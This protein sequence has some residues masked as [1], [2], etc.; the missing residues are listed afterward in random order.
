MDSNSSSALSPKLLANVIC[1]AILSEFAHFTLVVKGLPVDFEK[2]SEYSLAVWRFELEHKYSN[3]QAQTVLNYV[4]A[5]LLRTV[6]NNSNESS[7]R[8]DLSKVYIQFQ[9]F[10]RTPS[11]EIMN[12]FV[13][14]FRRDVLFRASSDYDIDEFTKCFSTIVS[15]FKYYRQDLDSYDVEF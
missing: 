9:S 12:E 2:Y 3:Q 14:C 7:Y 13:S 8:A 1:S 10:L 4:V 6:F 11:R 5:T 15:W